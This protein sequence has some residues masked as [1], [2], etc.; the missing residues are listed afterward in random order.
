[1]RT[2]W[3]ARPLDIDIIDHGGRVAN[4]PAPTRTGSPLVLPHPFAHL[5]GFVLVPLA[6]IAPW[7]RHP[8]LGLSARELLARN[9][10]LARGIVAAGPPPR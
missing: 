4:W 8:I 2:R 6:E 3:S 7:W 5:R 1:M 10:R 9:P